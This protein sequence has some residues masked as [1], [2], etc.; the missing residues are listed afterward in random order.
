MPAKMPTNS[1]AKPNRIA[2]T[3][4]SRGPACPRPD[5]SDRKGYQQI[6]LKKSQNP[7]FQYS[8][9]RRFA[10]PVRS[11]IHWRKSRNKWT[12]GCGTSKSL[13]FRSEE[14]PAWCESIAALLGRQAYA[15]LRAALFAKGRPG[16]GQAVAERLGPYTLTVKSIYFPFILRDVTSKTSK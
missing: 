12:M 4:S 10:A 13:S 8:S 6:D 5:S 16:V 2:L 9:L 11:A 14:V 7:R 1:T 15:K 3:C